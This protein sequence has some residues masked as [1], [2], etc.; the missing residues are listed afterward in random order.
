M[1]QGWVVITGCGHSGIINTL[2][3]AKKL[4]GGKLLAVLGGMH[5]FRSSEER[6]RQTIAGFEASGVQ[7][8]AACHCTGPHVVAEF[9]RQ[10]GFRGLG[11]NAGQ[12][13]EFPEGKQYSVVQ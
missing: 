11:L 5:L 6:V 9:G 4:T 2:N 7:M 13:I 10:P 12:T 1:P 8:V 3:Y